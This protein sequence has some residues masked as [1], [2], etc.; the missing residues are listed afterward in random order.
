MPTRCRSRRSSTSRP[1]SRIHVTTRSRP[2]LSA[3]V[4]ARRLLPPPSIGLI[5]ASAARRRSSRAP[6]TRS[7]RVR[8]LHQAATGSVNARTST[9]DAPTAATA[10]SKRALPRSGVDARRVA[11]VAARA[12]VVRQPPEADLA[13]ETHVPVLG[14]V[15][16]HVAESRSE[17]DQLGPQVQHQRGLVDAAVHPHPPLVGRVGLGL[18]ALIGRHER[19]REERHQPVLQA[20]LAT[21][22]VQQRRVATVPVEERRAASPAVSPATGRCRRAPRASVVA[23]SQT[24][25]ADQACSFDFVYASG[26]SSQRSSSSPRSCTHGLGHLVGD[27][28]VGRERQVGAVLFDR[29]ERLDQDRGRPDPLGHLRR[30][31]VGQVTMT[32]RWHRT[33]PDGLRRDRRSARATT[34]SS[35]RRTSRGP[36]SRRCSLEAR[37]EVGRVRFD[38]RR[39]RRPGQHLQLRPRRVPDDAGASTSSASHEHGLRYLDVEPAQVQ[40]TWNGEAGVAGLPRRRAHDRRARAHPSRRG[41]R[42]PPLLRSCDPRRRARARDGVHSRPH[43]V[44]S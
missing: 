18:A 8:R 14:E 43:R 22:D 21:G 10:A 1:R 37:D 23:D 33:M 13:A 9:S 30:A 31:E 12:E 3:S 29:S 20:K 40:A 7:S 16:G 38:G 27:H 4:S 41:R 35:A 19:V 39:A 17:V 28:Q 24:V 36:A 2:S 6:S 44:A 11:D 26:G 5:S 42:L 32:H 34:G 25:P 15:V